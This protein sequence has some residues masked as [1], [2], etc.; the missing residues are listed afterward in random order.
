MAPPPDGSIK[1]AVRSPVTATQSRSHSRLLESNNNNAESPDS[2]IKVS[3]SSPFDRHIVAP[4]STATIAQGLKSPRFQEMQDLADKEWQSMKE[5]KFAEAQR[6]SSPIQSTLTKKALMIKSNST[7]TLTAM[8][9]ETQH[10]RQSYIASQGED[11]GLT[12]HTTPRSSIDASAALI[13]GRGVKSSKRRTQHRTST[14][15][16]D[17]EYDRYSTELRASIETSYGA[18]STISSS[19]SRFSLGG[20]STRE[21]LLKGDGVKKTQAKLYRE[22]IL[23]GRSRRAKSLFSSDQ[24]SKPTLAHIETTNQLTSEEKVGQMKR[25]NK[26]ANMLGEEWLQQASNCDD[27]HYQINITTSSPLK[28]IVARRNHHKQ[29]RQSEP[30]GTPFLEIVTSRERLR[31]SSD[32]Y[33]L[34]PAPPI[35]LKEK[36]KSASTSPLSTTCPPLTPLPLGVHPKAAALLGLCVV[37]DAASALT[38]QQNIEDKMMPVNPT[39]SSSLE[40]LKDSESLFSMDKTYAELERLKMQDENGGSIDEVEPDEDAVLSREERR[41]RVRK[42]SRWLGAAVPPHLVQPFPING[43]PR[44]QVGSGYNNDDAPPLPMTDYMSGMPLYHRRGSSENKWHN[45]SNSATKP[46]IKAKAAVNAKLHRKQ[47]DE[48]SNITSFT[49]MEG[50]LSSNG[51]S[52]LTNGFQLEDHK[53]SVK[54]NHK[55]TAVFGEAPPAGLL[56]EKSPTSPQHSQSFRHRDPIP[57]STALDTPDMDNYEGDEQT[58]DASF[59]NRRASSQY[60]LSIESI[61]YLLRKNPPLLKDLVHALEEEEDDAASSQA[62]SRGSATP[63]ERT[64]VECSGLAAHNSSQES[65]AE[66]RSSVDIHSQRYPDTRYL[67]E[68]RRSPKV[69]EML[70]NR[71]RE[72]KVKRHQKLGR[73]F[74]ELPPQDD[75]RVAKDDH[76]ESDAIEMKKTP[77]RQRMAPRSAGSSMKPGS[78]PRQF[79]LDDVLTSIEGEVVDD[80]GLHVWEKQELQDRLRALRNNADFI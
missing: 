64:A 66:Q 60:R 21:L 18:Q 70:E 3:Q 31:S 62:T 78:Y 36:A 12:S 73:W 16:S 55:L 72:R 50:S 47:I 51:M 40:M 8:S 37:P 48:G 43:Q 42:I 79:S 38:Y 44:Q 71:Q 20:D 77:S 65:I 25:S 75:E 5:R 76:D 69:T 35:H 10:R 49:P 53:T 52:K 45:A 15:V 56:V 28:D 61:E 34:E 39:S 68:E 22:Q 32:A 41:R 26:L 67:A 80:D 2:T 57:T 7:Q 6:S 9:P 30:L 19:S 33:M 24:V 63:V 17:S 54:R 27:Q 23:K 46:L 74:G 13:L 1:P 58:M 4:N 29:R 59:N 11:H 14:P